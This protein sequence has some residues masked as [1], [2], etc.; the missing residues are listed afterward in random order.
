MKVKLDENLPLA[1]AQLLRS[2]GI[3]T[4]TIYDEE[5]SGATDQEVLTA[6]KKEERVF[7]SFD[8]DFAD[9]RSYP[10]SRHKGI[11]V[12]RVTDQRWNVLEPIVYKILRSKVLDELH[13]GIAIVDPNRIRIRQNGKQN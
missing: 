7:I 1:M 9:I 11:V 13:G 3:D 10:F 12:I 4:D 8:T 6:A 2:E 5:L